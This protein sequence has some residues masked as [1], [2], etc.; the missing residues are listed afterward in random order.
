MRSTSCLASL[1]EAFGPDR[2]SSESVET[3]SVTGH[4]T[5]DHAAAVERAVTVFSEASDWKL[6]L[7]DSEYEPAGISQLIGRDATLEITKPTQGTVY[8]A[9][10]D[11]F[12]A[13][14][15][16]PQVHSSGS[17]MVLG[18][19]A[20]FTTRTFVVAPWD[21]SLEAEAP[22][23]RL[24]NSEE[25]VDA[26]RVLVRDLTG[27][28]VPSIPDGWILVREAGESPLL[29]RWKEAA[30]QRLATLFVSELWWSENRQL[31]A[32]LHGAKRVVIDFGDTGP[33]A[34]YPILC[35]A[36]TWLLN[37]HDAEA[38][39]EVLVRRIAALVE[40]RTGSYLSALPDIL[41]EALE[42]ARLDHR[43]YI[44]AKTSESIK[45]MS[46]LRK[47]VGEDV[48]RI[49]ERVHRLSNGLL[50]ALGVLGAGLG[51]RLALLS[52]NRDLPSV[53]TVFCVA[54]L[55]IVWGGFNLQRHVSSR[56]LLGDL[57]S[58]RRWHRTVHLSLKRDEYCKLALH[59]ILQAT[60][61]YR[62]TVALT[63]K[64][65]LCA[66]LLFV[67]AF[68]VIP[69]EADLVTIGR[70]AIDWIVRFASQLSNSVRQ[71]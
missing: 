56:S 53:G 12:I 45:A 58:M 63:C 43:A 30:V 4:I 5:P 17:V 28:A 62:E 11:G 8:F 21:G 38:R 22:E 23:E 40:R 49:A 14:L 69:L 59:P 10:L 32:A 51:V 2:R 47:A 42:G 33:I 35:K 48:A 61:L 67:V 39:H 44:R 66:S 7:R 26:A 41:Q 34:H 13:A 24:P 9:T 57:R 52:A 19:F 65:L 31:V 6:Q 36:A 27:C 18:D 60:R 3:L 37:S 1:L 54:V 68:F 20:S 46:D 16:D 29:A 71:H 50:T 15:A 25:P 55:L 70:Q 64:I